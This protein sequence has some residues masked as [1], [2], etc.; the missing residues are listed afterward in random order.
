M[1]PPC[2][3]SYNQIVRVESLGVDME[4]VLKPKNI[5]STF[6]CF[7]AAPN[8]ALRGDGSLQDRIMSEYDSVDIQSRQKLYNYFHDDL[9]FFGYTWNVTTNAMAWLD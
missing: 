9:S 2:G 7:G 1:C 5:S 3:L 8:G 6:P 4:T